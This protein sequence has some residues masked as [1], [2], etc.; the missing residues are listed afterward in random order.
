MLSRKH[1]VFQANIL[2]HHIIPMC[3]VRDVDGTLKWSSEKIEDY[4]ELG[5]I[6]VNVCLAENPNFD[7]DKFNAQ[8]QV[9]ARQALAHK[10]VVH[11]VKDLPVL[12]L[13]YYKYGAIGIGKES[14][15]E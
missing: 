3:I 7:I 12:R 15:V 4:R 9:G 11:L 2:G 8:I 13:A 14:R 5:R 6:I 1:F 10:R